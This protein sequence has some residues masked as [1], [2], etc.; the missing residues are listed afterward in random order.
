MKIKP[1]PFEYAVP[2]VVRAEPEAMAALL[3]EHPDLVQQRS[4]A[5]HHSTLLHYLAANGIEDEIQ[6]DPRSAYQ[7]LQ[8]INPGLA[9]ALKQDLLTVAQLLIDAGADVD[10]TC[11]TYGGGPH[12][13]TLN[14]LVSSGHPAAAE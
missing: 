7:R 14:L 10:A 3:A 6:L 1:T 13:T 5:P 4:A 2:A 12:Q 11:D 9:P 8:Q